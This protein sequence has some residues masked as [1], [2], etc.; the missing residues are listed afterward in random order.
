[1]TFKDNY[2]KDTFENQLIEAYIKGNLSNKQILERASL[3]D[4]PKERSEFLKQ[5]I[6][7]RDKIKKEGFPKAKVSQLQEDGT[8]KEIESKP[9]KGIV[10]AMQDL[11][12]FKGL[13]KNTVQETMQVTQKIIKDITEVQKENNDLLIENEINRSND[14]AYLK[15]LFR[16]AEAQPTKRE[17]IDLLIREKYRNINKYESLYRPELSEEPIYKTIEER[18]NEK[19][20]ELKTKEKPQPKQSQ[21]EIEISPF[22][23]AELVKSLILAGIVKGQQK[24]IIKEFAVFFRCEDQ[25]IKKV[26][27]NL[28]TMR[29]SR[30][31]MDAIFLT[32]LKKKMIDFLLTEND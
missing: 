6:E 25:T 15:E 21:I 26:D 24:D 29:K 19:I 7:K 28:R 10:E 4:N 22:Q 9:G 17:K 20:E 11:T 31:Q 30:K 12:P 13:F 32:S 23:F 16:E 14:E 3:I 8:F 2:M 18:I 5:Q 1:M 27:D